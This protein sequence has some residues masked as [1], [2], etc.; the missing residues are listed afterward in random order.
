MKR[1]RIQPAG[2][3]LYEQRKNA[4]KAQNTKKRKT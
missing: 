3:S 2:Q 1:K 4:N